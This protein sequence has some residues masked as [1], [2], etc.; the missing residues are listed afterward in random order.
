MV[1]GNEIKESMGKT[2]ASMVIIDH[3]TNTILP[4]AEKD[5]QSKII[6]KH[7]FKILS[8]EKVHDTIN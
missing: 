7:I 5:I 1:I 8:K 3:D 4:K 6:L 2:K